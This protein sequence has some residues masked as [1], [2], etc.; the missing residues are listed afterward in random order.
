M[1]I[2][3]LASQD[4]TSL[5]FLLFGFSFETE[6]FAS[7]S[8]DLICL[9]QVFCFLGFTSWTSSSSSSSSSCL[10][11]RL[12][13]LWF[14]SARSRSRWDLVLGVALV[15]ICDENRMGGVFVFFFFIII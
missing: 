4:G 9:L 12:R 13:L 15:L 11:R 1:V 10:D 6:S 3:R 8:V 7:E 14:R 5:F 2:T